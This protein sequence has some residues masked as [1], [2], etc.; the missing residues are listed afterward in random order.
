MT[1]T[2]W[3]KKE[4]VFPSRSYYENL[5][6]NLPPEGKKK[7]SLY[8]EQQ[9]RYYATLHNSEKCEQLEMNIK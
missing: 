3:L 4:E 8:Y 5:L 7:V 9:Y 2:E 6:N 1:F